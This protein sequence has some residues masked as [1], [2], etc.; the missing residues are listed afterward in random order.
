MKVKI[1]LGIL[2]ACF[3]QAAPGD[4]YFNG[5]PYTP[6]PPGCVTLPLR[7]IDLYGD[8]MVQVYSGRVWLQRVHKVYSADPIKNLGQV[9]LSLYRMSCAEP[10]R[11]VILIEFKLPPESGMPQEF[12]LPTVGGDGT[13]MHIVPF[14]LKA[15]PNTWG[16]S[17]EQNAL[18]G[19][20]FGDY[21]NGWDDAHRFTWR[22]VL[23]IVPG[24]ATWD[25]GFLT[26]YY[27]GAIP[28]MF[29]SEDGSVM[30]E[31]DVPA[32]RDVLEPNQVLPLNGRLSGAWIEENAVDQGFILSFSNPVPPTGSKITEPEF[33]DLS[34]FLSWY[35]FDPQGYMLWL[36]GAGHFPQGATEVSIPIELVNHG[37]FL[38]NQAAYRAAVGSVQLK[39]RQCNSLEVTYDL[40][41]L[42]LGMG[43][44]RL[45]R[46]FALE[47]AGYPCRDYK[48]RLDNLTTDESLNGR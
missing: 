15:E 37:Q 4:P 39:A 22:Y 43:D 11:S 29:Y 44:M 42:G 9:D 41:S 19:R 12:R 47:L 14:E 38:G 28:L 20:S 18:T 30:F 34:V 7:Q 31:I 2:L 21:T 13:A 6:Y 26:E 8:N 46:P 1:P 32:T 10:N 17:I 5:T 3:Y 33:S 25:P 48:A 23:D 45:Q 36:T 16:Q 24:G 40:A 27:N 35:T